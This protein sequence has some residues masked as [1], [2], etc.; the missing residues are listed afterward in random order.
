MNQHTATWCAFQKVIKFHSASSFK[1]FCVDTYSPPPHLTS[2]QKTREKTKQAKR[3]PR[4]DNQRVTIISQPAEEIDEL[5]KWPGTGQVEQQV[6]KGGAG[7][8]LLKIPMD[9]H[10][11]ADWSSSR[12][13]C[14]QAFVEWGP[15]LNREWVS[16][17]QISAHLFQG[18]LP[19]Q[20]YDL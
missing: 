17:D 10:S 4:V 18:P 9:H 5:R 14:P 11:Q 19:Y 8:L 12:L 15:G 1:L 7:D 3:L 16:T 6:T 20:P 2:P 13:L